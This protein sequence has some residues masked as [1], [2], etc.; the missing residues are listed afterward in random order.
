M[1]NKG[2]NNK[3]VVIHISALDAT[4]AKKPYYIPS[5]RCG[6]HMTQKDRPRDKNWRNWI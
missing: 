4:L 3:I 5:F 6:K 2:K 1:S